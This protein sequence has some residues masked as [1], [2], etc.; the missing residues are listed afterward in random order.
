[1]LH[2]ASEFDKKVYSSIGL[3]Q[4]MEIKMAKLIRG[5]NKDLGGTMRLGLY[6]AEL[7]KI[8]L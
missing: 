3:I 7:L 4:W 2:L 8:I 1:M 5:T 6:E